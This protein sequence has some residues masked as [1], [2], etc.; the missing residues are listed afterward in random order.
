[1]TRCGEIRSHPQNRL[2]HKLV[3]TI[4]EQ[5]QWADGYMDP[6]D[7][8]RLFLA[9]A[10]GQQMVANPFDLQAPFLVVNARRSRALVVPEM[11]DLITQIIAF[12]NERGVKWDQEEEAA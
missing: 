3:A 4:A 9:A 11:A 5:V 6:E 12:G 8:K 7:W 2:F 10:Y 1:M